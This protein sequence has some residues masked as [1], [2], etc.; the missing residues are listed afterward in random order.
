MGRTIAT[1]VLV[2]AGAWAQV[3]TE[4][5]TREV[6]GVGETREVA[7]SNG[8]IE[9][10]QQ[11][12]GVDLEA[13]SGLRSQFRQV[14]S[15]V[16]G[17]STDVFSSDFQQNIS[18]RTKGEIQSYEAVGEPQK[19]GEA[20]WEV[21]LLVH[22]ERHHYDTPGLNSDSRRK[23]AVMPFHSV[24]QDWP[25][26]GGA[27]SGVEIARE[28]GGKV[29]SHVT[30]CRRFAV[31]DRAYSEEYDA[32]KALLKSGNVPPAELAKLGMV[33]GT[34][35]MLVASV[36]DFDIE[37]VPYSIE[38]TGES[39]VRQR[40]HLQFDYRIILMATRQIK[41]SDSL[42]IAWDDSAIAQNATERSFGAIQSAL[43]DAAA[44]RL[45]NS[46]IENIYP[47]TV[48]G[49]EGD[50]LVLNQGGNGMAA[51]DCY[52]VYQYGKMMYDPY[53]KEPLGK[54]EKL[55]GTIQITRVTAKM[56]YARALDSAAAVT[57][58]M[59]CRHVDAAPAAIAPQGQG[60]QGPRPGVK[61]PFD[62]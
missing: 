3:T 35:Y 55:A 29:A 26:G 62:K 23:M 14:S 4:I 36:G 51:G 41:W 10:V 59:I 48:I 61:L 56:A 44:V 8:L 25:M 17:A 38:I 52:G 2:A 1:V 16:D 32:E 37:N 15:S 11:I 34:D 58:G 9:A 45:T 42:D 53:T 24:K 5:I 57:A 49:T 13:Q 40:A 60:P 54:S 21:T 18:K 43:L 33:L 50:E 22:V 20:T 28:L 39:G 12:D 6:T 31:L 47:I 27:V 7:I 30:Q 19:K 46:I